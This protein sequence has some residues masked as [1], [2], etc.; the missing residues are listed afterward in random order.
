MASEN[1]SSAN[2][3]NTVGAQTEGG[4][5]GKGKGRRLPRPPLPPTRMGRLETGL[6][7][8]TGLVSEF[9]N[10]F[11]GV[12]LARA[13]PSNGQQA[14]P[15]NSRSVRSGRSRRGEEE[16]SI[17][18]LQQ[19]DLAARQQPRQVWRR[20]GAQGRS[21]SRRSQTERTRTS[22]FDR[23]AHSEG[24]DEEVDSTWTPSGSEELSTTDLRDRLN[25]R[26]NISHGVPQPRN[27]R[28]GRVPSARNE[29]GGRANPP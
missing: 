8:L 20:L 15:K 25:A 22:V 2:P 11:H 29:K 18:R 1:M 21:E 6:E 3:T 28:N 19:R 7:N 13:Q 4:G 9:V 5:A 12:Q 10:T 24:S 26:R 14:T 16:V 27:P 23:L 17:E